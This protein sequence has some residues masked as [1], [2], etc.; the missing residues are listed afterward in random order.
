MNELRIEKLHIARILAIFLLGVFTLGITPWE[1][2]HKHGVENVIVSE[3][4][5][6]HNGHVQAKPVKC[7]VCVKHFDTVYTS[8]IPTFEVFLED[9]KVFYTS[10]V[11]SMQFTE[12]ISTSLRGPPVA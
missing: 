8:F 3:E 9:A 6:L 1:A 11:A 5:C 7:I 12:L 10:Q 2:M 4:V